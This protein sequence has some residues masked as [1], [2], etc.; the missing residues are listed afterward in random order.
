MTEA[1]IRRAAA[2]PGAKGRIGIVSPG[3]AIGTPD[4]GIASADD[5]LWRLVAACI[6]I[7]AYNDGD[8]EAWLHVSDA[9]FTASTISSTALAEEVPVQTLVSEGM[10]WDSFW[11][12]LRE[13]GYQLRGMDAN[14]WTA[15]VSQDINTAQEGHPLWPLAQLFER[16]EHGI[17]LSLCGIWSGKHILDWR[18][19]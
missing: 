17:S 19:Q 8:V 16:R 18:R 4:E 10:Y 2:T 7:G 14:S 5:Y 9:G 12:V 3:L 11:K 15:A 13:A 1:V 6:R